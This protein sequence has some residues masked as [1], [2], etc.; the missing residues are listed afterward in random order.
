MIP[1]ETHETF[2]QVFIAFHSHICFIIMI[3]KEALAD[4]D[5]YR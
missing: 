3:D 1:M 2:Q 5:F 4:L